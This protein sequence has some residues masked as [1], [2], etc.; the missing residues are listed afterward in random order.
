[1]TL[2]LW[3]GLALGLCSAFWMGCASPQVH[4][5]PQGQTSGLIPMPA[6]LEIR[7]EDSQG[8]G[9][10]M[11]NALKVSWPE[12]WAMKPMEAW[13][14]GAGLAWSRSRP[15][16]AH[17]LWSQ[18]TQPLGPEGYTLTVEHDRI[19]AEAQDAEG[20]FRAWTTLRQLMPAVCEQGCPQGFELPAV[21]IQD[22][23]YLAHRGLLLDCCRHFMA[24]SFVK[25]MI[26]ALALQKMNVLHWHLTE[27]QG[28]RLPIEAYPKLTEV[29]GFRTEPDGT[30][31]GGAYTKQDIADIVAYAAE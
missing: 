1:M 8:R 10:R 23:A 4:G 24:P 25:D 20:A 9:F 18:T 16:D 29:G 2:K 30:V 11:D 7:G 27:D 19:V 15:E 14:S 5:L 21:A 6:S 12:H 3:L 22:S 31:H 28:W 17:V 26:D 13:L